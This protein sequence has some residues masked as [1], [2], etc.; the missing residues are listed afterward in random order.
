MSSPQV[1][2]LHS[3]ESRW[4]IEW[5]PQSVKFDPLQ[6]MAR[7]Y[8]PLRRAVQSVDIV[9][10]DA[11]LSQYKLVVAPALNVITASERKILLPT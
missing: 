6:E 10:P 9:S 7:Y 4:A 11:D 2:L 3:Y 1:A 5:Q 8:A